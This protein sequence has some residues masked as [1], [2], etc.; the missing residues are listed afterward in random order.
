MPIIIHFHYIIL[1]NEILNQA[2]F[3]ALFK[4]FHGLVGKQMFL[5]KKDDHMK[6][7]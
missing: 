6:K 4:T 5:D 3:L 2:N 7:K 1:Y